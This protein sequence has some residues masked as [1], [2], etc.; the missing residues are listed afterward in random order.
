MQ[1]SCNGDCNLRSQV[2]YFH[3]LK[4]GKLKNERNE[5]KKKKA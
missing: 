1:K 5:E 2:W 4:K 3:I